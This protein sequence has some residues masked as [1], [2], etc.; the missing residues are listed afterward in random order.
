MKLSILQIFEG[1]VTDSPT[2][3]LENAKK[4]NS[5]GTIKLRKKKGINYSKIKNGAKK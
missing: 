5:P 2:E 4:V 3:W 1:I